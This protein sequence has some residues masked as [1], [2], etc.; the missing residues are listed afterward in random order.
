MQQK[1]E[2]DRG[3][4]IEADLRYVRPNH[5][6]LLFAS[7]FDKLRERLHLRVCSVLS[8]VDRSNFT[9]SHPVSHINNKVRIGIGL[10]REEGAQEAHALP[11]VINE[12]RN[13]SRQFSVLLP[14]SLSLSLSLPP[15]LRPS[16]NSSQESK[17]SARGDLS[18]RGRDRRDRE[19]V[20]E[21]AGRRK[22]KGEVQT[23][24]LHEYAGGKVSM[25]GRREW[26]GRHCKR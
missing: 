2:N 4:A 15:F 11:T 10:E 25:S 7:T 5:C 9:T 16:L 18:G 14:P 8:R 20:I 23:Q 24:N 12:P 17:V 26:K 22:D 19:G 21:A 6:A 3:R 13:F 1:G